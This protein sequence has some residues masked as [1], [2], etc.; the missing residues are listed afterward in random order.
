M[1]DG[2]KSGLRGPRFT[3]SI[4]PHYCEWVWSGPD[5]AGVL[6]TI[7]DLLMMSWGM[8]IVWHASLWRFCLPLLLGDGGNWTPP[9][10]QDGLM[11][12]LSLL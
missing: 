2:R 11:S 6:W 5:L 9:K 1:T 7:V 4:S 12:I 8:R 3:H 10:A